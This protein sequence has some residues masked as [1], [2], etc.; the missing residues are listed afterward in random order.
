MP[1]AQ[2]AL[3]LGIETRVTGLVELG[4]VHVGV[5]ESAYVGS[6]FVELFVLKNKDKT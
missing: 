3:A 5:Y 2:C 1:K 6:F 4:P